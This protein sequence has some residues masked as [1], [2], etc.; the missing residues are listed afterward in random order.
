MYRAADR[1][2]TFQSFHQ[3]V[4]P[5]KACH[6]PTSIESHQYRTTTK[7]SGAVMLTSGTLSLSAWEE[8]ASVVTDLRASGV[9]A[10]TRFRGERKPLRTALENMIGN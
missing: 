4:G 1:V 7:L 5:R 3:R 10:L 6:L 2:R 8:A 9:K